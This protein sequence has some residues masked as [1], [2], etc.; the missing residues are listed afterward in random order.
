MQDRRQEWVCVG[1][2][3]GEGRQVKNKVAI[4]VVKKPMSFNKQDA[5]DSFSFLTVQT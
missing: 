5:T 3:G 4:R 2:E 1:V